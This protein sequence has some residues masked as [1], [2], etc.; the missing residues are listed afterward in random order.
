MEKELEKL[1]RAA[2]A[3]EDDLHSTDEKVAAAAEK[4]LRKIGA[5][6]KALLKKHGKV[7][8]N[9][10]EQVTGPEPR[11]KCAPAISTVI[12]GK[13]HVCILVGKEGRNCLYSCS[14]ATMSPI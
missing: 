7:V 9:H 5:D 12:N 13:V 1:K 11:R 2:T 8:V 3:L 6:F 10:E 4:K 14:P